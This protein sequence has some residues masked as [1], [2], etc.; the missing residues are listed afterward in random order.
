MVRYSVQCSVVI[1][2]GNILPPLAR[3]TISLHGQCS[4]AAGTESDQID[5]NDSEFKSKVIYGLI[6][7][8]FCLPSDVLVQHNSDDN[9]QE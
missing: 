3:N 2:L 6:F 1:T 7:F 4:T 9:A 8:F 5:E